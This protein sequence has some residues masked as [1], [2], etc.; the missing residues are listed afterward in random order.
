MMKNKITLTVRALSLLFSLLLLGGCIDS[1]VGETTTD[2]PSISA[3]VTVGSDETTK[4]ADETTQEINEETTEMTVTG[5]DYAPLNYE[6]F[7]AMWL[8]QFDLN[9]VYCSGGVQRPEATFRKLMKTILDNIKSIGYNTIILQVRP[10]ADSMY[11]SEV[12]PM[13]KYVV[14]SYGK[15]ATYDPFAIIIEM[16]HERELSVHAWINPMRA[17]TTSEIAAVPNEY[18]IKQWY[19]DSEKKGKYVVANGS[20]YYLNVAY[21]E[22]RALI[23]DGAREILENYD[24]DGLHMDDY[25]YPTED[26]S[27]DIH[28]YKDYRTSGGTKS[29][30]DFRRECL[31]KLVSALYSTAKAQG[32]DIIFGISPAGNINNVRRDCADVDTWCSTEGY[33]DYICPQVYFGLEHQ[34]YDFVSVC[35]TWSSIIKTD[36]VKLI[37]GMSLGKAKSG[38]DNYAGS[39]KNEWANNKDVLK[40]CLEHTAS[41]DKCIGVAYFCYQYYYNPVSGSEVS[42]T[43]TERNNFLPLLKEI[44]WAD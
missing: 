10:N 13:S 4:S 36:S 34:N 12:Y 27:F 41:L 24:I 43:R 15:D 25:F 11:P 30:A 35:K 42:E 18:K 16:A 40:R 39:G 21:D 5:K 23:V 37:V 22:V 7:K 8:S 9:S 17:M 38:V 31:N 33:I 3:S 26:S 28:A 2:D 14:G 1:G 44:T 29:L 32:A 19:N 6:D 20:N